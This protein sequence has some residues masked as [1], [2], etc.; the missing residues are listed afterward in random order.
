MKL[1]VSVFASRCILMDHICIARYVYGVARYESDIQ[2]KVSEIHNTSSSCL[3]EYCGIRPLNIYT[4][5]DGYE[6]LASDLLQGNKGYHPV[7]GFGFLRVSLV[8]FFGWS[9]L[10][11]CPAAFLVLSCRAVGTNS[12]RGHTS[13]HQCK[14]MEVGDARFSLCG[15]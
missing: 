12:L 2:C 11:T 8:K 6:K 15:G 10:S 4:L 5:F 14:G 13:R 7:D 3:Y 9:G 1:F